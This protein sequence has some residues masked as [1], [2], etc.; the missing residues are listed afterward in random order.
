[1]K[2]TI[3]GRR[4][5]ASAFRRKGVEDRSS[6]GLLVIHYQWVDGEM[7]WGHGDWK[8]DGMGRNIR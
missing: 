4:R 1:M 2:G 6:V 3:E 8:G 5:V 7:K